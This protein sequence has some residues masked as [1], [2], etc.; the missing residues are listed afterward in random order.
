MKIN[1]IDEIEDIISEYEEHFNFK[2]EEGF[3]EEEIA[4]KLSSPKEIAKEYVPKAEPVNKFQ[5][6]T[7]VTGL[8][9][10]SIPLGI[11]SCSWGIFHC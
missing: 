4:K 11:S 6:G 9:F 3:T 1:N 8:T 2:L 5:K 10:V 7:I